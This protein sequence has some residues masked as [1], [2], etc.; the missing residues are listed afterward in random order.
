MDL[1]EQLYLVDNGYAAKFA[2]T[3]FD[4]DH[5]IRAHII[6]RAALEPIDLR[7]DHVQRRFDVDSSPVVACGSKATRGGFALLL[8]SIPY[9]A[10]Q[11]QSREQVA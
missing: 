11:T 6:P 2:L 9:H 5:R 8:R 10:I 4:P 1:F 3:G 7:V